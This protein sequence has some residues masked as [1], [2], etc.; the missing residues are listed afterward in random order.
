MSDISST[1]LHDLTGAIINN[2]KATESLAIETRI[3]NLLKLYEL[4]LITKE[5]LYS[6]DVM[7]E[8][9]KSLPKE[10]I[11]PTIAASTKTFEK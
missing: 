2:R 6:D 11:K 8:Y 3:Q 10:E 9:F 7:K 4:K 5:Q 1:T